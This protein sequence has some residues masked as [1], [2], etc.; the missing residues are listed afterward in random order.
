MCVPISRLAECILETR[1][2]ID[3]SKLLAPIVGHVGDGNFHLSFILDQDD[4]DELRRAEA[5]LA[6]A[7]TV[8]RHAERELARGDRLLAQKTLSTQAHDDLRH[9]VD[10]ARDEVALAVVARDTAKRNLA[11]TRIS[12]PFGGTVDSIAVDVGDFVAPGTP[13]ATLVDLPVLPCVIW[14]SICWAVGRRRA[15]IEA[16]QARVAP[17]ASGRPPS[18]A[19]R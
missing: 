9:A 14:G 17:R 13:V 1:R 2:D 10:R 7:R 6:A 19:A 8:L 15:A 5:S 4:A 16:G 11:D 18:V 12:A 3:E